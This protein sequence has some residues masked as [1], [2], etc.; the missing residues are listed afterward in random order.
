MADK[1]SKPV[2][3]P[4]SEIARQ[5]TDALGGYVY[6]LD[7]T[8]MTWLTLGDDEALHIEFAEDIAKS[9]NGKLDLTQIKRVAANITLRSDGVAKLIT[10][11]WEFQKANPDRK[12]S[13][14]LL[15]TNGIGR[16]RKMSFPRK[17]P[18]LV[19]WRTAARAGADVEPIRAA[20][21]SLDLPND[22]KAFIESATADELRTRVVRSIHWLAKS[23]SQDELRQELE[24]KLVLL[25]SRMGVP[26]AASKNAR[27][28]LV[29]ALLDSVEKPAEQRY[30]T[31]GGLL[32]IF[33][34]KTFITLP[35]NMLEGLP[36]AAPGAP[37]TPVEAIARDVARI[38]LP[39]RAAL[40]TKEIERLQTYLVS[41]GVL[42]FHGAA[43]W[44][45][46]FWRCCW[47]VLRASSGVLPIC[48]SFQCQPFTLSSLGSR[49]LSGKPVRGAL[50][51]MTFPLT[52]T[53]HWSRQWVKSRERSP[54]QMGCSL[55]PVRSRR[56]RHSA[57]GSA[58]TATPSSACHI[59]PKRMWP[60]WS[61]PPAAILRNG[62]VQ[63]MPL[64][65]AATHNLWTP[66]WRDL[67][68]VAGTRR[69]F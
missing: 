37:L 19:Y 9:N 46:V 60:T 28:F 49:A 66:V 14:S 65:A 41:R 32:E 59:S 52:P 17:L 63:S 30:V 21:L 42:W 29:G 62:A 44:A 36:I 3:V 47:R 20:L 8:V 38:P 58:S 61:G 23:A 22:L 56:I 11:V 15:T 40:R 31:K 68:S 10:S 51:W 18:G 16:E 2:N 24:E 53:T 69:R 33:Q 7:H 27:H 50:F 54:T 25:G 34:N 5:A 55:S 13:G 26:A 45:K 4:E 1:R 48:V 57:V 67:S 43:A 12:V 35:P 39:K 6:Q 64:R